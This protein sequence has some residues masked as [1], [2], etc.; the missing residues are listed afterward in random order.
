MRPF[1]FAFGLL[2]CSAVP[3]LAQDNSPATPIEDLKQAGREIGH[4]TRDAA[5]DVGHATRDTT[6]AIGHAS[7]KTAKKVGHATR[8]AATETGHAARDG[9]HEVKDAVTGDDKPADSARE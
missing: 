9:A 5:K 8:D 1:L 2:C 3:A 6:R 7:R 4:A